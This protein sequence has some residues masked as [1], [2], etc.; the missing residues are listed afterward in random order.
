MNFKRIEFVMLGMVLIAFVLGIVFYPQVPDQI[1]S[2][3]NARGEVDGY[4]GKFWGVFL[5]PFVLLGM[6]V[7]FA[8]NSSY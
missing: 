8:L 3:W 2:H 5:A 4:M 7:L 1:A 6:A